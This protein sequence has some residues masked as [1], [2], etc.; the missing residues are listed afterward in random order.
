MVVANVSSDGS[1]APGTATAPGTLTISGT[2]AQSPV[3]KLVID[4]TGATSG[5]Y[6]VLDVSGDA[7][8]GGVVD[9]VA[10]SGFHPASG[11]DFTFLLFDSESGNFSQTLFTNWSCPTGATCAEVLGT[12]SLSL[13]ISGG[14]GGT[15]VPEPGTWLLGLT[16]LISLIALRRPMRLPRD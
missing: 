12:H 16:G 7:A 15:G 8:L 6:S 10:T 3:G 5:Q 4:L 13:D 9:F 14:G 1:V 11:E 2:Y